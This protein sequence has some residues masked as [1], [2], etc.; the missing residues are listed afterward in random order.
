[1]VTVPAFYVGDMPVYGDSILA[2]MDGFS[3]LPFRGIARRLGSA[4][5]YTEFVNAMDVVNGHKAL[6]ERLAYEEFERPV[7]FQLYDDDPNRLVQAAE[8]LML[9]RPDILDVNMGCSSKSIASRGAG[10]GLLRKPEKIG[11][12]IGRLSTSLDVPVTAKIRLGWDDQTLNYVEVAR[13]IEENGGKLIAVHGRTKEQAY[14]GKANWEAIAEIKKAVSIPVIGNGD[15]RTVD[16]KV[17]MMQETGC[18]AVMIGRGAIGNPWIFQGVDR[19]Q[20]SRQQVRQII[21]LH[22]ERMQDFYG[23]ERGLM[24]FR[25]HASRYISTSQLT[26]AERTLLLNCGTK[27]EFFAFLD[28]LY[29]DREFRKEKI[30]A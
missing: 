10:A 18:D 20:V 29:F 8:A 4:M 1:M 14:R 7:V 6:L 22:L 16:D 21:S 9:L 3:D 25:K 11:E 30:H 2:P 13:I 28:R 23:N 27:E 19:G 5:S 24:L 26:K 15:I 12:I 17:R